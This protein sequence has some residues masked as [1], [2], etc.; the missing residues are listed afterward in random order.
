MRRAR[1]QVILLGVV[2]WGALALPPRAAAAPSPLSLSALRSPILLHGS[3]R[4][5]FR[6]PAVVY[7]DGV[8]HL[9]FTWV[10]SDGERRHV[11][12][13]VAQSTSANLVDWTPPVALTAFDPQWN[14]SSPGDIVRFQGRWVM[15]VSSYPRPHDEA[16]GNRDARIWLL[17]SDDLVT[18]T[19]PEL[20]RVKGPAVP[21][22]AMGR[23]IDPYLYPDKDD[24]TLWWCLFKQKGAVHRSSSRDLAEWTPDGTLAEGENPCMLVVDGSY[25]LFSSPKNG[26]AVARSADGDHWT[27]LGLLTLGQDGWPW[28]RGRI[29]A[30]FVLDLRANPAIGKYLMFFHGTGP[31]PEPVVFDTRACLGIAWSDDLLHWDW[32]GKP[33]ALLPPH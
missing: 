9:F 24:P 10:K 29:T 17:R 1:F 3:E 11:R 27:K 30:G 22:E 26:I 31:E 6:D 33:P 20:L 8:F 15:C 12:M 19:P 4:E 2:S 13:A 25:Y 28:A 32:P 5:A 14:F 16:I 23:M 7:A 18:W 21:Q